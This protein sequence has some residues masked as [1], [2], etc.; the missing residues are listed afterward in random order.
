MMFFDAQVFNF[1]VQN[2]KCIFFFLFCYCVFGILRNNC[3]FQDH[4]DVLLCL[5]FELIFVNGV[6]YR[7]SFILL[8]VYIQLSQHHLLKRLTFLNSVAFMPCQR[9][10]KLDCYPYLKSIDHKYKGLFMESQFTSIDLY[11]FVY[12]STTLS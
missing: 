10:T 1:D 9:L 2:F 6:R 4:V 5:H 7:S 11:V 12:T 8:L 3:L